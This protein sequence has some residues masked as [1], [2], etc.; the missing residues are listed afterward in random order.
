VVIFFLE[1]VVV[2]VDCD[3]DGMVSDQH[4]VDISFLSRILYFFTDK[5]TNR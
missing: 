2:D 5:G 4:R 1:S 3:L